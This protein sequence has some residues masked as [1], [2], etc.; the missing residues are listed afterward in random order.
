MKQVGDYF[1]DEVDKSLYHYTS[2][3]SLVGI[4]ET[5]S[6]WASN[7]YYMNDSEEIVYA[8]R[9]LENT[10]K[11]RLTSNGS[12][13][14]ETEFLK[15]F[16]EWSNKFKY[17]THNIFI[18]SLSEEP[19]L[20]SQWRSYTPHSKGVSVGFS[21]DKLNSI[22]K[23]NGLRIA[24][25]LY[26][27]DEQEEIL[28]SLIEKLLITFRHER[29]DKHP[30]YGF[31][32]TR[33]HSF[34]E[35]FRGDILQVLSIIKN[36]S[37]SEEQEWRLISEFFPND[38]STEIKFRQGAAMLVPFVEINLGED[39]PLFEEVI[40]GPSQ[41]QNLSMSALSMFLANKNLCNKTVNCVI[42]Y[43]EW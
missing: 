23:N 10:L 25:C 36:H 4:A 18:F 13:D 15:Q 11:P 43:R 32:E 20:L 17:T 6:L 12:D 38:L 41:H 14:Q 40:L 39:K 33:Y 9:L 37:F 8:N 31:P 19:S 26:E 27:K 30:T 22:V 5:N 28:N 3:Y 16:Y 34:L 7:V 24:K 21:P 29:P 1:H 2:I 42:P 35:Q